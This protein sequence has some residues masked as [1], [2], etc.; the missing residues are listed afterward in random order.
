MRV[1]MG[2]TA[3]REGVLS[4]VQRRSPGGVMAIEGRKMGGEILAAQRAP[5]RLITTWTVRKRICTS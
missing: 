1:K 4:P 3:P 5:L 2:K